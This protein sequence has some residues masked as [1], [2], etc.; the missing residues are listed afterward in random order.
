MML[1]LNAC[2]VQLVNMKV[3][4]H[5]D[6]GQP[7]EGAYV[8]GSFFQDQVVS[9]QQLPSHQGTTD[10]EG[11]VELSGHEELYVDL[12]V[13]KNGYYNSEK[14]INVRNGKGQEA[15]VLLRPKREPIAMY[16]KGIKIQPV[17]FD[18]EFG[19]DFMV[20]D[21]VAPH[22]KGK[23]ADLLLK[24]NYNEKDIWN[25]EYY[26]TIRFSNPN[27]GLTPF[28]I[29]KKESDFKS[30]YVAPLS[31][32]QNEW[33]FKRIS[34]KGKKDD[35][36]LYRQRNYYFRVRTVVNNNGEIESAHYGKFYG[37][38]PEI[39][40]YI[41]PTP[42]DRNVE[43]DPNQNLFKNLKRDENVWAP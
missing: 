5:D 34:V 27:D 23:N 43:F 33:D 8:R 20:G 17:V 32:Y 12:R 2:G 40:H 30:A 11:L 15:S 28:F 41:N 24:I 22:G 29:E 7:V 39:K 6:D 4:V 26:L 3:Q 16:V 37:E 14:R 19:Y 21:Y 1:S 13:K 9:T 42:N 35:T 38:F 10:S 25:Y 18:Q 31:G 36:N